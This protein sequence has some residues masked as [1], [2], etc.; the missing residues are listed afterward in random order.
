VIV[1]SVPVALAVYCLFTSSR[2]IHDRGD[3]LRL[4][5]KMLDKDA[6]KRGRFAVFLRLRPRREKISE[7]PN[8][9][10]ARGKQTF[11][12]DPWLSLSGRLGDGTVI[13]ESCIDLIRERKKTPPPRRRS[14]E[15]VQFHGQ[16]L[17]HEN[18]GD[19]RPW[20]RGPG[21]GP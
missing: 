17:V 16:D 18:H 19:R 15:S 6:G 4:I 2:I 10:S 8:P 12:K 21:C 13:S 3:F 20:R 9:H 14:D 1:I 11:F 5:L 7:G